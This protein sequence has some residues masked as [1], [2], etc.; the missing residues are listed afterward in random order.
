[1]LNEV[2]N[3]F[4]AHH[5]GRELVIA[6]NFFFVVRTSVKISVHVIN[7]SAQGISETSACVYELFRI[8]FNAER[9]QRRNYTDIFREGQLNWFLALKLKYVAVRYT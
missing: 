2:Q 7:L 4:T 9:S 3:N 8:C 5:V 6:L 1:M